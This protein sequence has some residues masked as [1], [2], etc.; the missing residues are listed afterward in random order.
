MMRYSL[1]FHELALNEWKKLDASIRE[2]FKKKLAERLQQPR[3]PSSALSGMRDCYKI[4]LRSI[5]YRLVYKVN[6]DILFVTVIYIGKRE[7]LEAYR[8]AL[9][10]MPSEE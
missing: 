8:Q 5:G 4:K 9:R 6:D 2:Q 1:Q 10:R 3:V 7:R